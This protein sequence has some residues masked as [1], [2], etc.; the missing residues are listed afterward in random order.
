[1]T[2]PRGNEFQLELTNSLVMGVTLTPGEDTFPTPVAVFDSSMGE[3]WP[4]GSGDAYEIELNVTGI[5]VNG[6]AKPALMRIYY[7]LVA[8]SVD[9]GADTITFA[10]PHGLETAD[11]AGQW[12]TS[13]AD[14]P[15]G[16]SLATD[17]WVIKV[18]DTVIKVATS[19][20]NARAGTAVDITDAGTGTH[21]FTCLKI[22]DIDVSCASSTIGNRGQTW[23]CPLWIP[24]LTKIMGSVSVGNATVGTAVVTLYLAC[25]PTK[26]YALR[27]CTFV[28][29]FGAVPA[30]STGTS[31]TPGSATKG[32]YASLGTTAEDLRWWTVGVGQDSTTMANV[33]YYT[34][35]ALDVGGGA[36]RIAVHNRDI[37]SASQEILTSRVQGRWR[38]S[39]SGETVH[40]RIQQSGGAAQ[41]GVHCIA[42]GAGGRRVEAGST[43]HTVA[44]TVTIDGAAAANGETVEIF[45][46]DTDDV[47]E[48]VAT[49]TVA[50]SAG[51]FTVD[52]P[53]GSRLYFAS[54]DD[55]ADAGRS[56][57][58]TPETDTFDIT[59]GGSGGGPSLAR[60][61][62]HA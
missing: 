42:Y 57:Y 32:S 9:A 2:L 18:S 16:L 36:E 15:A 55:G 47:A 49:T 56:L 40:A 13:A 3:W 50:G 61:I 31:V 30:S 33:N 6:A 39:T 35:L 60:V 58:G 29:T 28:R 5:A 7:E 23:A 24:R 11:G 25:K 19:E 21:T 43:S 53:D 59:I 51:A 46:V 22:A 34:D 26:E 52:V 41:T 27:A 1:M 17:Y 45:A 48:L 8:A 37:R 44:G 62:N 12:T 4:S 10:T 54:Y 38:A 14:L 20:A